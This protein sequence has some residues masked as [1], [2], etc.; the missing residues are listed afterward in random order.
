MVEFAWQLLL[1]LDGSLRLATPLILCAMAGIFSERSGIVDI[2]LE[3]KMLASAFVA[4]AVAS[5]YDSALLGVAGAIAVG[6]RTVWMNS[7]GE[8][9]PGGTRADEEIENL[10]QL[11]EAI[12]RL[13]RSV[14]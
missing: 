9:W 4:A 11:P 14:G 13:A 3:G 10:R 6:M 8:D 2:S 5:I 12:E 1:T 7:Q